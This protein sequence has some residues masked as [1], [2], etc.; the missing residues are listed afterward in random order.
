[1]FGSVTDKERWDFVPHLLGPFWTKTRRDPP[2][3]QST[4]HH[5]KHER[6]GAVRQESI[7]GGKI[8]GPMYPTC[9][10]WKWITCAPMRQGRREFQEKGRVTMNL[11]GNVITLERLGRDERRP[12]KAG[13]GIKI[14][15]SDNPAASITC[16]HRKL[17]DTA[18]LLCSGYTGEVYSLPEQMFIEMRL[19][20]SVKWRE[21]N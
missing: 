1:M 2:V 11:S 7:H 10:L 19:E 4:E 13:K 6:R 15:Y 20:S 17:L 9:G 14:W 3:I 12:Q 8:R 16:D 18:L 5:D 21:S